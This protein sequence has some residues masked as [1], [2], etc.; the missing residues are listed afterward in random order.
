MRQG[1]LI[2][3]AMVS[4]CAP[5]RDGPQTKLSVH[6]EELTAAEFRVGNRAIQGA[7]AFCLLGFWKS[8]APICR[9]GLIC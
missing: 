6:W 4:C 3:L 8:M 7:L 2:A 5:A 9:W 1:I